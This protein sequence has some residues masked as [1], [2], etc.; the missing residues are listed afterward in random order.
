[1]NYGVL[2]HASGVD[3]TV[4][5]GPGKRGPIFWAHNPVEGHPL[6]QVASENIFATVYDVETYPSEQTNPVE[7]KALLARVFRQWLRQIFREEDLLPPAEEHVQDVSPA[8]AVDSM[9]SVNAEHAEALG[10]SST[11]V[12][13]IHEGGAQSHARTPRK[14]KA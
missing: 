14:A 9:A 11:N 12:V 5:S 3:I 1:M 8:S 13:D 7:G 4:G 10:E 6:T 2:H